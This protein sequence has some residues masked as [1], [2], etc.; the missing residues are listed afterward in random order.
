MAKVCQLFSG[1]SGNSIFIADKGNKLLIDAGVTAKR[2]EE[3]LSAIGETADDISAMLITHEHL[4][5]I[6][7]L[8]VFASRYDIPVFA[9]AKVLEALAEGGHL[10]RVNTVCPIEENMELGGLEILPFAL[11]H[12]SVECYGFRLNLS[13][14]KSV[15]VCTDTGYITMPAKKAVPGSDMVFLESNHEVTMLENG[16]YPYLL[17]QRILSRKGHL[18]NADCAAFAVAL[19]RSGVRRVN[20]SHLSRDNNFPDMARQTTLSA[21]SEAGFREDYDFRLTVSTPVNQERPVI[22]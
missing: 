22:L 11:S 5:H 3:G 12:D 18:S 20:L 13:G 10:T 15:S 16:P 6:K 21:L 14:G 19:V 17:K 9:S 7:G 1:S 8:R 4:D 2:L